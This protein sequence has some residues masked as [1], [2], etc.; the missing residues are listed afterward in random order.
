VLD[1][2]VKRCAELSTDHHLLVVCSVRL[3]QGL[4]TSLT[5]GNI[6]YYTTILGPHIMRNVIVSGD[7][8]LYQINKF[9]V[10][11]LFLL[12][13]KSFAGRIWSAGRRLETPVLE[14]PTGPYTNLQD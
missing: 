3:E 10:N 4:Q 1:I 8:A 6:S 14:K 7:V 5:E 2:L 13:K 12:L 11:I 9:F